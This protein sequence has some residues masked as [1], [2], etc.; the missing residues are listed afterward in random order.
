MDPLIALLIVVMSV[1]SVLLV[2]VGIQVILILKELRETLTHVNRSLTSADNILS[3][4]SH[5]ASNID[6]TLGGMKSGLK[7]VEAFASWV[8][9]HAPK[10]NGQLE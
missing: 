2:I 10:R 9:E 7:L 1:L 4:I 6:N 5:S 3:L 8:K